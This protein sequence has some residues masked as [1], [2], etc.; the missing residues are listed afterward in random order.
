MTSL[1]EPASRR[2]VSAL[3]SI[4]M[5]G[6]ALAESLPHALLALAARLVI[7]SVFWASGRTKVDG[8]SIREQTYFLFE[9]EYALPLVDHR[10]AAVMAT[11]A[12]H[13]FPVLLVMGLATRFSALSLLGM[14]LTIQIFVYPGAWQTH[15]LWAVC[16]LFLIKYGAGTLSLDRW[17]A[18][19]QGAKT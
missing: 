6:R 14:A 11:I 7:A 17:L 12:E 18:G 16:L 3:R 10:L 13:V 4:A 8:L 9:H 19:R 1:S 2:P 5:R 15:G